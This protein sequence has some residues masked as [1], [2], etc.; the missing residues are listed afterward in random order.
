MEAVASKSDAFCGSLASS[1]VVDT[2]TECI[3]RREECG[4]ITGLKFEAL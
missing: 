2:I 1:P 4:G 3:W